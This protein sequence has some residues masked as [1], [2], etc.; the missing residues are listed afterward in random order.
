MRKQLR[1]V[2]QWSLVFAIML[3]VSCYAVDHDTRAAELRVPHPR[4]NESSDLTRFGI[5]SDAYYARRWRRMCA[6]AARYDAMREANDMGRGN[7]C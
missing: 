2:L 5:Y 3:A 6:G 7:P 4:L 1:D